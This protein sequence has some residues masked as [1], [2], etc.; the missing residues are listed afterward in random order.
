MTSPRHGE[1]P[2]FESGRA[3]LDYYSE[4]AEGY[5]ELH[6]EEQD[7]KLREFMDKITFLPGWNLLDVG[8]GTGSSARMLRN[9]KWQGLEPA[10]GLIDQAHPSV[11]RKITQA[12]AENIPFPSGMFDV[13]LSLT[14][15][16]NFDDPARG[17][18]EMARVCKENGILLISFLKKSPKAEQLDALIK[19]NLAVR[20]SWEGEK[21]MMYVCHL[22]GNVPEQE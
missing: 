2:R 8:C 1:G 16:Q 15:L 7:A 5:D 14:A 4:I 13:I 18:D 17:L 10:R 11:Q 3:H 22:S 6:G 12:A 19:E 21:D 20:E 9:V